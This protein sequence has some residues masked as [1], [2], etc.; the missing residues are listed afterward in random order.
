MRGSGVRVLVVGAGIAGLAAAR[1]LRD[2]GTTV[3]ILE[4]QSEPPRE[5]TGIYLPGNAARAL[6]ILGLGEQ[7]ADL[8]VHIQRQRTSDH[9]GRMLFDVDVDELWNGVG[10]CLALPR[11]ALH[12]VLLGGIDDVPIRWGQT[13]SLIAADGD[14]VL[15]ETTE[16]H[17]HQYDL[18][19][20]ADGVHSSVRK[21][22]FDAEGIRALG[23]HARRFVVPADDQDATWSVLLCRGSAFLTI[24]I[25]N[26]HVYCYCDGPVADPL[27]SIRDLLSDYAEPVPTLLDALDTIGGATAVHAAQVEEVVL[28]SWSRPGVLLIGDAAHATSPNMAQG[29]AMALEDAIVLAK[30]LTAADSLAEAMSVYEHRRRPRTDWVLAQTHRRDRARTLPPAIRNVVL[31]RLGRRIFRSNYQPL[32]AQP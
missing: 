6:D 16:G 31:K 1:T 17:T 10:S 9:H 30:S 11:T 5:G 2:C 32:R 26:G 13:P 19:L 12:R 21:L 23:Q 20:G 24:P 28:D 7:V 3:E 29:A 8:A 22:V 18:V 14:G 25:G 27:P 15:V 4:R